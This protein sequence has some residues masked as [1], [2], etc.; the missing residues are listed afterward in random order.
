MEQISTIGG[1]R[2]VDL[3]LF[4]AEEKSIFEGV[5]GLFPPS[6]S[7]SRL[8]FTS[9][10]PAGQQ[11]PRVMFSALKALFCGNSEDVVKS[12]SEFMVLIPPSSLAA[13]TAT[14]NTC[15]ESAPHHFRVE[16]TRRVG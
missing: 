6:R 14:L 15:S 3:V 5:L 10:R 1:E 13:A 12:H 11:R 16:R 8:P 9:T 2:I 4:R 7:A